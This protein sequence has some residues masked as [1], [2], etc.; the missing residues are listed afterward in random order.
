MI[1]LLRKFVTLLQNFIMKIIEMVRN[2]KAIEKFAVFP[3]S[4]IAIFFSLGLIGILRHSMWRDEINV[5]LIARDSSSVMELFQNIK[6]EGHPGLWYICLYILNLL[7]SNPIAMQFFHLA[8]ATAVITIFLYFSPFLRWQKILF[9][10]GYLPF[11]EYLLISRNYA[12]GVLLI[13]TFCALFPTRQRSYFLLALTLFALANANAYGLIISISLGLMLGLD[14]LL[15]RQT[16]KR[17]LVSQN[18]LIISAVIFILGIITSLAQLIPPADSNLAGGASG[19]VLNFNFQRL[20]EVL[21]TIWNGY[22]V[23]I[24]PGKQEITMFAI[25]STGLLIF[26]LLSLIRQPIIL[27]LYSFGTFSILFFS[28][29][30]FI[31]G[32]RHHGNLYILLVAVLWLASYYPANNLYLENLAFKLFKQPAQR[33][34]GFASQYRKAFF[35]V[36][37]SAQLAAGIVAF[38]RDII[39]PL[40]ASRET[41]RFIHQQHLDQI[42]LVGSKDYAVSPIGGYLNRKIYYPEIKDM[43]SFVLFNQKRQEVNAIAVLEQ[44]NFLLKQNNPQILLILNYE[45]DMANPDLNIAAIANFTNSFMSDEKYYLYLVSPAVKA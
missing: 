18:N 12:I 44:V 34:I 22:V 24:V 35:S 32:P 30:K 25:I 41:A 23:V 26:T 1:L 29:L 14:Y 28:Y 27:F 10:F 15:N 6:Y 4:L 17:S 45:L 33:L 9:C 37:L 39:I 20:T 40:S 31:G 13:F 7:T 43:G 5:W 38:T 2:H 42:L 16:E 21:T 8:I 11:Y 3:Q 36:L 19:W